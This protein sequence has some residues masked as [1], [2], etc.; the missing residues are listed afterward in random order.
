MSGFNKPK[1]KFNKVLLP[2]PLSPIIPINSFL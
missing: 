2:A 1:I